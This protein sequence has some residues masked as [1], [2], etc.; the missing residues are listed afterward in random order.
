MLGGDGFCNARQRFDKR[1]VR[2]LNRTC[3]N[4]SFRLVDTPAS[5][6]GDETQRNHT[7]RFAP[8]ISHHRGHAVY[9]AFSLVDAGQVKLRQGARCVGED[10]MRM[11]DEHRVH[12]GHLRNVPVRVFERRRV[13]RRVQTTVRNHH[14]QVRAL[15]F[16]F[17]DVFLSE[18]FDAVGVDHAV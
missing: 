10:L 12:T 14:H 4:D 15:S 13:W 3:L 6:F 5:V 7:Q 8:K 1:F 11:A 17:R 18:F 2:V 9:Q 16:H